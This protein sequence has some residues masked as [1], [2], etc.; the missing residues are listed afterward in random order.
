MSVF[1]NFGLLL[2]GLTPMVLQAQ[3][4]ERTRITL[5]GV[6]GTY[7][8]GK[9]LIDENFQRNYG[10]SHKP[11]IWAKNDF[12]LFPDV[13]H[14]PDVIMY[15]VRGIASNGSTLTVTYS[16]E[17]KLLNSREVLRNFTPTEPIINTLRNIE[18]KDWVL[19]RNV[20]IRKISS[21]GLMTERNYLR[22]EKGKNKKIL[23][24]DENGRFINSVKNELAEVDR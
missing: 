11:L 4:T 5:P 17:G 21:S 8:Q 15:T 24:L 18:Y 23:C 20:S 19:K 22:L 6:V 12:S 7:D 13:K 16:H 10:E 1:T 2:I 9:V 14:D 3:D